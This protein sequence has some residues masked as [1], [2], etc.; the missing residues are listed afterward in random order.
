MLAA[1]DRVVHYPDPEAA[2]LRDRLAVQ[3]GVAPGSILMGAGATSENVR[4]LVGALEAE[5]GR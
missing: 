1:I 3:W 2:Q 5:I 4:L